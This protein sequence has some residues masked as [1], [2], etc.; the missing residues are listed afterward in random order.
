MIQVRSV[1]VD[2]SLSLETGRNTA[3]C[4]RA[5][6]WIREVGVDAEEIDVGKGWEIFELFGDETRFVIVTVYKPQEDTWR[7]PILPGRRR[8]ST[9][10]R[11]AWHYV[12]GGVLTGAP[13]LA[14]Q[15]VFDRMWP[16]WLELQSVTKNTYTTRRVTL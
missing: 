15:I 16:V 11:L 12:R 9:A 3:N 5:L 1:N 6:L 8:W 10:K 14:D 7:N 2:K 4:R 13:S